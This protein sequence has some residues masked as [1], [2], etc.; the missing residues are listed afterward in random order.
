MT[1]R[2]ATLALVCALTWTT[3]ALVAPSA[4][5]GFITGFTDEG[6]FQRLAP[7]ER[8]AAGANARA[9][10]ARTSRLLVRWGAVARSRPPSREV[11]RDPA[12]TGYRWAEVDADI[13]AAAAAGLDP[14]PTVFNAPEWAQGDDRPKDAPA[15]AWKPSAEAYGNFAVA[16]A[17]RYSGTFRTASGELLPRVRNWQA[18]NEPN[19]TVAIAPQWEQRN[20]KL[21]QVGADQ[22]RALLNAFYAG[23]KSVNRSN[24]V[25]MG[26]LAP[27]GDYL[28][29]EP[30]IP[31]ARFLRQ[32]LCVPDRTRLRP[33]KCPN[34]PVRFDALAAH[35]YPFSTPRRR[36]RRID[37][38]LLPDFRKLTRPLK[39]ATKAGKVSPRR[40]K[41]LWATEFSWDSGPPDPDGVPLATHGLY[42]AEALYLLWRQGVDKAVWFNMR[43]EATGQGFPFTLQSGVYFRGDSVAQ[44][45]PKPA[46]TAFRF[47]L[48][49]FASRRGTAV[50]GMG[51]RRGTVTV[52]VRSGGRWRTTLRARTRRDRVFRATS[53]RIRRGSVIR[54]VSGGE[55]SLPWRVR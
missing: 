41:Q 17:R 10:G 30:R 25:G 19:L 52:Q 37:D 34:S 22:Y 49:G 48:V 26:G 8:A 32:L 23:V 53:A 5:P 54:A 9:A 43:D 7:A 18:W 42:A 1:V 45:R 27:Y 47:P 20:G 6:A 39:A 24:V 44:D 2:K 21:T 15:G 3:A 28:P 35:P 4:A 12:W 13:A 36:A 40:S 33:V 14:L 46:F 38:V 29:G 11:A 31:P 51:P 50:W 16:I 55:A